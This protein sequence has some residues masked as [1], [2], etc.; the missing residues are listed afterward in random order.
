[1]AEMDCATCEKL[2]DAYADGE[3]SA[4]VA[5]ALEEALARCPRC[6]QRLDEARLLR[7]ALRDAPSPR[8][9]AALRSAILGALPA[10]GETAAVATM[11]RP[12]PPLARRDAMRWAAV[13]VLALG[14]GWTAGRYLPRP[15]GADADREI[16][17]G[18]LRV[19]AG[20]RP[21]EVASSDRHTVKPWFAGR[22]AYSPPVHDLTTDGFPL[23]GGRID[24]IGDRKVAV[25]VYQRNRHLLAVFVWPHEKGI[26]RAAEMRDGFSLRRWSHA[27]FAFNAIADLAPA[28]LQRFA[29]VLDA[30]LDS[31][32]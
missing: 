31:E 14:A 23:V 15:A 2:I 21:V 26:S 1:M 24:V 18:Y 3:L 13:V 19:T 10:Q 25:L 4:D 5:L 32:P 27:G 28:D 20:D 6:R 7:D 30:R 22:I 9:P 8:A 16:V 29:D 17:A 12:R 11:P